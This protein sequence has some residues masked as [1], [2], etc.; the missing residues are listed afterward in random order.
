MLGQRSETSLILDSIMI[1]VRERDDWR[2]RQSPGRLPPPGRGR[3]PGEGERKEDGARLWVGGGAQYFRQ[4]PI[5]H[6]TE[7]LPI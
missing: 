6:F 3:R 5:R 7:I 2:G 4:I 1:R